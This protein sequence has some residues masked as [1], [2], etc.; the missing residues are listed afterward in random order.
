MLTPGQLTSSAIKARA[1]KAV[2]CRLADGGNLFFEVTEAGRSRW[3]MRYTSP[4]TKK[5]REPTLS[6]YPEISLAE[7]RERAAIWRALIAD[8]KD[9]MTER[10]KQK[11]VQLRTVNELWKNYYSSRMKQIESHKIELSLYQR[12]IQPIIGH[13]SAV[14]VEPLMVQHILNN[15]AHGSS[16]RPTVANDA[17]RLMKNLFNHA[18]KLGLVRYNPVSAFTQKD[19]GGYE[20]SRTITLTEDDIQTLFVSIKEAGPS[21]SRE[22]Y[23]A[24]VLLLVLGPRKMELL[25]AK[26]DEFELESGKWHKPFKEGNKKKQKITIPLTP[27]VLTLLTELKVYACRSIYVFP[28]KSKSKSPHISHDTL[29]HA[30]NSLQH[31][32]HHFTVHDLRRTCRTLLAALGFSKYMSDRYL[33]HKLKGSEETYNRHDYINERLE[34][35]KILIDHLLP[36]IECD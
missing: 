8:G 12:E 7:A 24:V 36:L 20:E 9:P 11:Q 18:I 30:L 10:E 5:R 19:A 6:K 33:N 25:G 29:N 26:W 21:F 34:A 4:I 31:D 1:K 35:Q 27:Y 14:D 13:I 28:A 2:A 15:I 22:N 16:P 23:I 32:L 17:L 3:V